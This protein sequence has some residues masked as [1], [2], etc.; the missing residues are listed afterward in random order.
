[1]KIKFD[2]TSAGGR[3]V[4]YA[5]PFSIGV[6]SDLSAGKNNLPLRERKFREVRPDSFDDLLKRKNPSLQ[7]QLSLNDGQDGMHTALA[8]L[9]FQS[10]VDFEPEAIAL[11]IPDIA[12]SVRV[13]TNLVNLLTSVERDYNLEDVIKEFA[14]N[15]GLR[16]DFAGRGAE[17]LNGLPCWVQAKSR[18]SLERLD[19]LTAQIADFV[20]YG[21]YFKPRVMREPINLLRNAIDHVDGYIQSLIGQVVGNEDFRRLEASWRSLH[22][23]V[24]ET[25]DLPNVR[26]A[27]LD[28]S[29]REVTREF[30]KF[31]G[32]L[33]HSAFYRLIVDDNFYT[34]GARPFG[35]LIGDYDF[36]HLPQDV[37]TLEQ[38]ADVCEP[39]QAIFVTCVGSATFDL[40]QMS[41]LHKLRDLA[42]GF[43]HDDYA[44]WNAFRASP[45]ARRIAIV[46]PK[47][48]LR[49]PYEKMPFSLDP[50]TF[51]ERDHIDAASRS[52]WANGAFALAV[53]AA[54]S[55]QRTGWFGQM[56][57]TDCASPTNPTNGLSDAWAAA[58]R[59][60]V[61]LT[62]VH[63]AE[64]LA[65]G[66]TSLCS[67][68]GSAMMGFSAFTTCYSKKPDPVANNSWRRQ[69]ASG[70]EALLCFGRLV[71]HLKRLCQEKLSAN[72]DKDTQLQI[73]ATWLETID[74]SES[75]LQDP[76]ELELHPQ[77][78]GDRLFEIEIITAYREGDALASL[79]ATVPV[80]LG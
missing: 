35:L 5:L 23:L 55:L 44:R 65:L 73:I 46:V 60:E 19:M 80:L 11:R 68:E 25:A 7:V 70:F 42:K 77:S 30:I 59:T 37:D 62:E 9:S 78:P 15:P 66:F 17:A 22:Y 28:C 36:S 45:S 64:L 63:V 34:A 14:L 69:P 26:V 16:E 61:P 52:L 1:M 8:E 79:A 47:F 43:R 12:R 32:L 3:T 20:D 33:V 57:G 49:E 51:T 53:A 4:S 50:V 21:Q 54:R 10:I 2:M 27:V 71:H 56:R 39:A 13:K 48:L 38:F 58:L 74:F 67:A 75:P 18:L 31:S 29:K 76:F 72:L 41:G 40:P 24:H 6:L